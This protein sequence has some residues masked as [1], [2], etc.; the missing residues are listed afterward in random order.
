MFV[1]DFFGGFGR[2]GVEGGGAEGGEREEGEGES[3]KLHGTSGFGGGGIIFLIIVT[4]GEEGRE[5]VYIQG[6][7]SHRG[8]CVETIGRVRCVFTTD[9]TDG[10]D[11]TDT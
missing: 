7:D 9:N 5:S 1:G 8:R 2:G 3:W 11:I 6:A 10:A 4:E